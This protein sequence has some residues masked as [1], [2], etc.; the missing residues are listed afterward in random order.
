M[1]GPRSTSLPNAIFQNKLCPKEWA[2][3]PKFVVVHT[4]MVP[5]AVKQLRAAAGVMITAS[6]NP[7]EDNGYKVYG[8]NGCQINS[9][10]DAKI[11]VSIMNNLDPI[12]W[13]IES[14]EMLKPLSASMRV[15][16]LQ[17]VSRL[18]S[19]SSISAIPPAF[20]YTAMHGVG[21]E[22]MQA[23][24]RTMGY[25]DKM[26]V[27]E[28]Q[29]QPNPDFPTVTYPNPEEQG[30]LDLAKA[31]ANRESICLVLANDPVSRLF[32]VIYPLRLGLQDMY[33]EVN[34]FSRF[35]TS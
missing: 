5:F 25:H 6:H 30:A 1:T 15:S 14:S 17:T 11:A 8:S 35:P 32:G 18:V 23:A 3:T 10:A 13:A 12:V 16:Y 19:T 34:C 33:L 20:V 2:L 26:V 28:E 7:A 31:T 9:P 22:P 21:F 24:L 27:V 4:P 29:A